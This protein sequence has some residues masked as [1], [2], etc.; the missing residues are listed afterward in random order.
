MPNVSAVKSKHLA[1]L[2]CCT[3]N[4]SADA[5]TLGT[6]LT[7]VY[8]CGICPGMEMLAETLTLLLEVEQ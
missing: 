6:A 2:R 5:T 3:N 4:V 1:P 8:S 7:L